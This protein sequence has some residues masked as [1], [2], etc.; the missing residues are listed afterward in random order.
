[1][2]V[3][4]AFSKAAGCRGSAPARAPQS[5]E[6]SCAHRSAGGGLR[7]NPRRGFPLFFSSLGTCAPIRWE[8]VV[9][10]SCDSTPFLWCLPKETVSS[11][12]R[13]ALFYLGGSTIRVSAAASVVFTHLRP[14]WGGGLTGR[15]SQLDAVGCDVGASSPWERRVGPN[16]YRGGTHKRVSLGLHP[17]SLRKS[18]EM[19]WNGQ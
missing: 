14:T 16:S 10:L 2:K 4:P 17:V 9:S 18:K 15:S 5:A 8:V 6:L 1:M 11:R 7:G 3:S 13:K 19:G 12:Q